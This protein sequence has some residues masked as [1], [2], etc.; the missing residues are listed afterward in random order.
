MHGL[1]GHAIFHLYPKARGQFSVEVWEIK[2]SRKSV[3]KQGADF[4]TSF[5]TLTKPGHQRFLQVSFPHTSEIKSLHRNKIND[6]CS[7]DL[8][9][10][11]HSWLFT[12]TSGGSTSIIYTITQV[13]L[14]KEL[15]TLRWTLVNICEETEN[16]HKC[17][18]KKR[19]CL[20]GKMWTWTSRPRSFSKART[21]VQT[22]WNLIL[23][24]QTLCTDKKLLKSH[25]LS[26][27]LS[28][29]D[30][31]QRMNI[32]PGLFSLTPSAG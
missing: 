4:Y 11:G 2:W 24:N 12:N 31:S 15:R 16:F 30:K 32:P 29:S 27:F 14:P 7:K 17:L 26:S 21:G 5:I 18:T 23:F 25:F 6:L 22:L 3:L 28:Q 8:N 20:M 1:T 13:K 9:S 10:N 19:L